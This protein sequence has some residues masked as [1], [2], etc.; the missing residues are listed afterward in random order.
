MQKEFVWSDEYSVGIDE[1]DAQHK[2]LFSSSTACTK[3][4][5]TRKA[6]R[7]AA[8]SWMSWWITPASTSRW[9]RP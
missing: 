4:S 6:A 5:W 3:P 2:T 8:P 7:P 1:I 9:N